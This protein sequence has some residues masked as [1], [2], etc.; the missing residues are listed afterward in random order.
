MLEIKRMRDC[1]IEESVAA[2]NKGFEGYYFDMTTT[3]ENFVKRM[4]T[5]D[6]SLELSVVAFED[7]VP[8]GI[9]LNGLR[10][11]NGI[12]RSWN[13]GT[14][15]A[16]SVRGKG[17]GKSLMEKTLQ[18]LQEAGV[19]SASLE[20]VIENEAAIELYKKMG[21]EL[22]DEVDYM[23]LGGESIKTGLKGEIV[24][25]RTAPE[26]AGALNFYRH[27]FTWQS[28]WQSVWDGEALIAYDQ[29][30]T[31]IG[32]AYY[33]KTLDGD[34][35]H[36][37]TVLYQCAASPDAKEPERVTAQLLEKVY[38]GFVEDLK[39]IAVNIPVKMNGLTHQT[40]TGYGFEVAVKQVFMVKAI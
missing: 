1:S 11:H 31:A 29:N 28:Q 20:A 9:V 19:E 7:G 21:Y 36:I 37:R 12:K 33:K 23:R 35:K 32:Y 13:G 38:G 39:Y 25:E 3:P 16:L 34:G 26:K 10:E 5:E 6:L 14:G 15:V 22:M 4:E 27:D 30:R 24:M 40:L 8:V 2:W 18:L 17:V